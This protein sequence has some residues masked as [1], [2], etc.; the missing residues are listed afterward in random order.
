MSDTVVKLKEGPFTRAFPEGVEDIDNVLTRKIITH[1]I[2]DGWL[3]EEI[4]ER[5][6]SKVDPTDYNDIT[7]I[8]RIVRVQDGS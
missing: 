4:I 8:K 2:V 7:S 3:T 5:T 1:R 6:Y